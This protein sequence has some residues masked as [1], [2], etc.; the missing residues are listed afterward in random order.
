MENETALARTFAERRA[1]AR[2]YLWREMNERGLFERD[3]WRVAETMR[4]TVNG[5][6]LVLRPLHLHLP[7]PEGLECVVE[8]DEDEAI[9][10]HCE[11]GL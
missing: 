9:D 4:A 1:E 7:S 5:T 3:G 11:P 8:I 2:A 10:S 6:E